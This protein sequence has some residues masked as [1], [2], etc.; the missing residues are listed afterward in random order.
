MHK[1][2]ISR[3]HSNFYDFSPCS[4]LKTKPRCFKFFAQSEWRKMSLEVSLFCIIQTAFFTYNTAVMFTRKVTQP[5][6]NT[7]RCL[8]LWCVERKPGL[9]F[10]IHSFSEEKLIWMWPREDCKKGFLI[11]WRAA[12]NTSV[13]NRQNVYSW[14]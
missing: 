11:Q 2:Y 12:V 8:Y 7:W 13:W 4:R 5:I 10:F 3:H 1:A 9:L 6:Y 14:W